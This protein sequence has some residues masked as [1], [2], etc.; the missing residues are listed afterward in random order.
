MARIRATF[1]V[2]LSVGVLLETRTFSGL[3]D[4]VAAASRRG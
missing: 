4:L 3:R 2:E 1:G